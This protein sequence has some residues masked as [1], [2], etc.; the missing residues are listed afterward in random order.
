MATSAPAVAVYVNRQQM[1]PLRL[2]QVRSIE[3][4]TGVHEQAAFKMKISIGQ[5]DSGDWASYAEKE[6]TPLMPVTVDARLGSTSVRLINGLLT[7]VKMNFTTDPCA[8]EIELTALDALEKLKRLSPPRGFQNQPLSS[9]VQQMFTDASITPP[10]TSEIPQVGT[11]N[12][13]REVIMQSHDDLT[14][15][16][17]LGDA[18]NAEVYV[19]PSGFDSQGHFATLDLGNAL[20]VGTTLVVNQG[21]FTNVQNA[22]FYYDL[23]GPTAVEAAFVGADGKAG[24]PVRKTLSEIVG[25]HDKKL[26]GP[27]GFENVRRLERH[28]HERSDAL[29]RLCLAEL[30]RLSWIVI[31]KGE[32]DTAT[33]G[34]ILRPRR[35][36]RVSGA[37][38]A[39]NGTYLV[40]KVTHSITRDR[41]CQKFELRRKLGVGS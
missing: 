20:P 28:G 3:L 8:S 36:V 24:A 23:T 16:R 37:S 34:D 41:Y 22:Q 17:A 40:W 25:G 27:P 32:L 9:L 30:D 18:V 29:Q 14:F 6:F 39:F 19:E 5:E 11:S 1:D 13:N 2:S 21:K 33:F 26:L 10:S 4:E 12:P 35:S 38:G 31:G 7:Q 15:V